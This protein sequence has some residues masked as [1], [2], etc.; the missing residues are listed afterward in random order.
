MYVHNPGVD[1]Q[2][3]LL[4]RHVIHRVPHERHRIQRLHR[5]HGLL[6]L[7]VVGRHHGQLQHPEHVH[8]E[9]LELVGE[10][11]LIQVRLRLQE[12]AAHVRQVHLDGAAAHLEVQV[13]RLPAEGDTR[14]KMHQGC[15]VHVLVGQVL[16]V[17]KGDCNVVHSDASLSLAG[18]VQEGTLDVKVASVSAG[19]PILVLTLP[20]QI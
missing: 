12:G 3:H 7:R 10:L 1:H 11:R 9:V 20:R 16:Q 17:S 5:H 4:G 13:R 19:R 6:G 2:Q 8:G 15:H 14:P 18:T